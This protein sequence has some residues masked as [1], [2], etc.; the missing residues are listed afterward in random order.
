MSD[1]RFAAKSLGALVT[2]K[3]PCV[4]MPNLRRDVE[5][6]KAWFLNTAIPLWSHHG[7]DSKDGGFFEKLCTDLTPVEEPRRARL[8][9]RQIYVF[10]TALELGWNCHGPDLVAH[11]LEFLLRRLLRDD[12]TVIPSVRSDGKIARDAYDPYDYAFVLFGLASA[13]AADA[14]R[15][16]VPELAS[17]IRDRLVANWSHPDGGFYESDPAAPPLKANSHMHLLEAALTW[18]GRAGP[19]R[20]AWGKLAD[21]IVELCLSQFVDRE[22]GIIR[23]FYGLDW[24]PLPDWSG[25]IVEPGHQFEW[26]WLLLWWAEIRQRNDIVP[27]ALRLIEV[28]ELH[29]VDPVLNVA[30]NELHDDLSWRDS[31]ARLWPQAERLKAWSALAV[32]DDWRDRAPFDAVEKTATAIAGLKSFLVRAP[33]GLWW[34]AMGPGGSFQPDPARASSLYHIASAVQATHEMASLGSIGE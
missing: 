18:C 10:A 34:E 27:R 29:G 6:L 13:A 20:R 8:V 22:S 16:F 11:G 33:P 12:G 30:I 14:N 24:K 25:R 26:A 4:N 9:A 31:C 19:D 7:V 32:R 2:P 17:R 23:E 1:T 15:D 3:S 21:G 28:A 5:A